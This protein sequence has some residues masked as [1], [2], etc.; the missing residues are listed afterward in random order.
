MK[1]VAAPGGLHTKHDVP[2][3]AVLARMIRE[4][5]YTRKRLAEHFHRAPSTISD[6]IGRAY[7]ETPEL[8]P[9]RGKGRRPRPGQS[10]SNQSKGTSPREDRAH[11]KGTAAQTTTEGEHDASP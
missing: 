3:S 7:R 4:E 8:M 2:D 11:E 6:W 5:G 1:E 10:L 9:P